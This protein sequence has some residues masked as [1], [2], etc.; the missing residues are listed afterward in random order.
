MQTLSS[1]CCES[2]KVRSTNAICGLEIP[3]TIEPLQ[4]PPHRW[5]DAARFVVSGMTL[6]LLPKCPACVAADVAMGTGMGISFST[7][8]WVRSSLMI[9]CVL[10]LTSSLFKGMRRILPRLTH[11]RRPAAY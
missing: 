10:M 1:C 9:G 3:V 5:V 7:A 8:G 6:V 2:E 4:K 11:K